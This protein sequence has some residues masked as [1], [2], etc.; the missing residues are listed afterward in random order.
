MTIEQEPLHHTQVEK[1]VRLTSHSDFELLLQCVRS[2]R[3][4]VIILSG[5]A[6]ANPE[7][8]EKTMAQ[9]AALERK[10][11]EFEIFLNLID[12]IRSGRYSFKTIKI[13]Q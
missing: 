8:T 3:D 1:I 9:A 7:Q 5:Q 2:D 12:Q 6:R 11:I 10:A 4:E 13:K